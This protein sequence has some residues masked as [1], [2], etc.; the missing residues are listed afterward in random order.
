MAKNEIVK[1]YQQE[2]EEKKK[3]I[4]DLIH[5]DKT[6][7][8][9]PTEDGVEVNEKFQNIMNLFKEKIEKVVDSETNSVRVDMV[10]TQIFANMATKAEIH[11]IMI[12]ESF[13]L[14]MQRLMTNPGAIDNKDLFNLFKTISQEST[15]VSKEMAFMFETANKVKEYEA[16]ERLERQKKHSSMSDLNRE[17]K[18]TVSTAL[19]TIQNKMNRLS[20]EKNEDTLEGIILKPGEDEDGSEE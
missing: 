11:Q 12:H 8:I 18:K 20:R 7:Y 19:A 4:M 6:K 3:S 2:L 14:I 13:S 17:Q 1:K 15:A 16:A 5:D 10:F 9:V